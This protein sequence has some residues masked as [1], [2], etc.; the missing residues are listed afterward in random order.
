MTIE[1]PWVGR[2]LEVRVDGRWEYVARTGETSAA[3]ILA[4]TDQDD[5]VLVEQPRMPLGG[6][7][8]I[9]LP[10]GLVGDLGPEQAIEAAR[11]E[12]LE[13]TGF[14]AS[15]W[16]DLGEF[17]STPG[18]SN[19]SFR[20]FKATG[21][22][23]VGPGGGE[24]GE[25]ITVHVVNRTELAAWLLQQRARDCAVDAKVLLALPPR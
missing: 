14:E 24:P 22:T 9:E 16:E 17:V 23:R 13:E 3:I 21:L 11:R 15:T 25:N 8:C 1:R 2:F 12:L 10:A 5:V 7:A 19:E 18:M 20:L 6:R 4:V